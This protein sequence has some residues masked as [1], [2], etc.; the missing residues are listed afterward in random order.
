VIKAITFDFWDTIVKDD[1]DE[2]KRAAQGL[3][4][5][6]EARLHLLAAEI[7]QY[8]PHL[9]LDQIKAAF[10][11]ANERF[12]HCW[13]VDYCTPT[14]AARFQ[15]AY[16]FLNIELTPGFNR[17]VR[18]IE[19]MELNIPPDFAPGVHQ[20]LAQLAGR[21][22]LGLISDAIHTPGWGIRKLL[23]REGLLQYFNHW[24]FSDEAGRSKPDPAVFEQAAAGLEV[25]LTE[26]VHIGDRESNDV[27][28]PLA[29]GMKAILY[30][31]A[32]D[33]GSANTQAT[34]ICRHYTDLPAIL[35]AM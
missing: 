34:A 32:I 17:M 35:D 29:L 10:D 14:V 6:A 1:S 20:A 2:P 31:G 30:T 15:E 9:P 7:R 26:I 18:E 16:H 13:K 12:R 5:K 28:G 3:A 21:Y 4:S 11:Y 33:R 8:H 27:A 22:R 25:P 24:V 19:E 23:E